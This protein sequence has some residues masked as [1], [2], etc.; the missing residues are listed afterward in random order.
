[1]GGHPERVA[2]CDSKE[3]MEYPKNSAR[4][5]AEKHFT[6]AGKSADPAKQAALVEPDDAALRR[7][8]LKIWVFEAGE[9]IAGLA[10]RAMAMVIRRRAASLPAVDVHSDTETNA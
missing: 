3:I 1:M 10:R 8:R 2:A 9:R 7:L 5:N 4:L 6:V